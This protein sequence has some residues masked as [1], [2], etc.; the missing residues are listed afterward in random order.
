M[1]PGKKRGQYGNDDI[2]HAV[3]S[4]DR[5]TEA[6]D[7][8]CEIAYQDTWDRAS[9]RC[10]KDRSGCIEKQREPE[11]ARK[12]RTCEVHEESRKTQEKA[13]A[14]GDVFDFT[15]IVHK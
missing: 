7:K 9:K 8:V 6:A 5:R 14:Y 4:G 1:F 12:E 3:I 15:G 13:V 11:D 2:Q 10:R